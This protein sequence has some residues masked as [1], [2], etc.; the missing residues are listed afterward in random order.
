MPSHIRI[1][2]RI[3]IH[4]QTGTNAMIIIIPTAA[5]QI[6]AI[7][8]TDELLFMH[9]TSEIYSIH[10]YS[11]LS[12]VDTQYRKLFLC[13]VNIRTARLFTALTVDIVVLCRTFSKSAKYVILFNTLLYRYFSYSTYSARL[14]YNII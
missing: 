10:L 13:T 2:P 14:L 11:S 3:D 9:I 4:N 8:L 5:E 12:R 7:L 1:A 6:P